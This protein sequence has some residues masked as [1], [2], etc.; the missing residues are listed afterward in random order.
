MLDSTQFK[1]G[2]LKKYWRIFALYKN[3]IQPGFKCSSAVVG[4]MK[5]DR[6]KYKCQFAGVTETLPVSES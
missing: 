4:C 2:S 1:R 3:G 6:E 5:V